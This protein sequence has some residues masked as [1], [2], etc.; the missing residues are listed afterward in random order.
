[1]NSNYT[2][3]FK[4]VLLGE[5]AVGKSSILSRFAKNE[6]DDMQESTIGAA[7]FSKVYSLE[8]INESV[9]LEIWDTAGQERY[10][11]L[12]PMYYRNASLIMIV[13]D[14]TNYPSL[15]YAKSYLSKVKL[16]CPDSFICLVGNKCDLT[17][18]RQVS[19]QMAHDLA[20]EYNI[21]YFETSA[22]TGA[23]IHE[24]F[25]PVCM[26]LYKNYDNGNRMNRSLN[27]NSFK[28]T[29][30]NKNSCC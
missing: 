25:T 11:S 29:D 6:F 2:K 9:F 12:A 16:H 3:K 8:E 22:K 27:I 26:L 13:F 10:K 4:V 28:T 30:T 18:S 17:H 5:S 14:I 20:N 19:K 1:M 24:M 7:F 21:P 23:G 15:V